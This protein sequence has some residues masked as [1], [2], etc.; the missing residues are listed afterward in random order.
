MKV[1]LDTNVLIA[2]LLTKGKA[3]RLVLHFGLEK[4][5]FDILSSKEQVAELKRVLREKF[6]GV[7]SRAE[8][9]TFIN[10]FREAALMVKPQPGVK[11]SPDPDDNI[12]LGIALAG[13]ADYLVTGDKD[14]LLKLKKVAGTRIIG[15]SSFL[16]LLS[17][18]KR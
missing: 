14:D 5:A 12:I 4:E 7:L 15:L 1:V 17:P 10:R 13:E 11:H 9:G 2:A 8:V 16:K 6:P 18:Y 3:Y